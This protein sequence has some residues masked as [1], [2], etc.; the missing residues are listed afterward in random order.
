MRHRPV[1]QSQEAG[2]FVNDFGG[3]FDGYPTCGVDH[4]SANLKGVFADV[5]A[6]TIA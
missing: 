3:G 4:R 5:K 2:W 1:K 6:N